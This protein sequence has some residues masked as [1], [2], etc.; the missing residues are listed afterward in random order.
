MADSETYP[1]D[2]RAVAK[3]LLADRDGL[4]VVAGL[5]ACAWDI[6]AVGDHDLNFPL[7][8]AMGGAASIGLGIAL[9]QPDRRVLVLTGDGEMLMGMGSLATIALQKPENLAVVVID[10]ECYGETGMQQTHT[11]F[12]V[13]LPGVAAAVGLPVTGMVRDQAELDTVLPVI[14]EAPGPV[15]YSIKVKAEELEFVLPTNDGVVLKNRMRKALLR[16]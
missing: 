10:N 7:W 11:A 9:A 4:V 13:D 5:G 14:R 16:A 1:L 6:T 15:F 8:G 2:R 12:G 3:A